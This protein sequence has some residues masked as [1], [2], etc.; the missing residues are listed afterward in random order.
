MIIDSPLIAG[1]AQGADR[2][3]PQQGDAQVVIPAE[4]TPTVSPLLPHSI[5]NLSTD[6]ATISKIFEIA[7]VR[8]NQAASTEAIQTLPKG[9]YF[10]QWNIS[11]HFDYTITAL[12]QRGMAIEL[13]YQTFT[14]TLDTQ[15]ARVGTFKLQG[16][17]RL[18]LTSTG[19]LQFTT[20]VVG[21]AE[22]I[23]L[24][25]GVQIERII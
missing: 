15:L 12:A 2:V 4:I 24:D 18:L 14:I 20:G 7:E 11:C 21:V 9:L 17:V 16:S 8:I 25:G 22:T 5:S 23:I 3:I 13:V 1:L 6:I 10:I 19:V